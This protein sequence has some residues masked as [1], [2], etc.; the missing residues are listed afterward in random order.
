MTAQGAATCT[1]NF[2]ND[3]GDFAWENASNWSGDVLPSSS[4]VACVPDLAQ[5][6]ILSSGTHNILTLQSEEALTING[7][8]L[9]LDDAST[10]STL[11]KTL[12]FDGGDLGGAADVDV[13]ANIVY[14]SGD[15]NGSGT[16]STTGTNDI[17]FQTTGFNVISGGE[18]TSADTIEMNG[19]TIYLSNGADLSAT[20]AVNFNAAANI[21]LSGASAGSVLTTPQIN[22]TVGGNSTIRPVF[23]N[24][25]NVNVTSGTLFLYGGTGSGQHTGSFTGAG[26]VAFL[27]SNP[28]TN[29]HE[30]ASSSQLSSS[31]VVFQS[32]GAT[33]VN[34]TVNT[35]DLDFISNQ[36]TLIFNAPVTVGN[37]GGSGASDV[38]FNNIFTALGPAT[39]SISN[40]GNIT[41]NAAFDYQDT[42]WSQAGS[43]FNVE[44]DGSVN[45]LELIGGEVKSTNSSTVSTTQFS[46]RGLNNSANPVVD[47]VIV[48]A[49]TLYLGYGLTST[50]K[51]GAIVNSSSQITSNTYVS[52][53]IV[54]ESDG[55]GAKIVAG[56]LNYTAI[57]PLNINAPIELD[58]PLTMTSANVS[59]TA[60]SAG[61]SHSGSWTIPAGRTLT[62]GGTHDFV[63]AATITGAGDLSLISGQVSVPRNVSV[64]NFTM[65]T[66]S[67][68]T[69]E[70]DGSSAGVNYDV[71]N[72]TGTATVDGTLDVVTSNTYTPADGSEHD[73]VTAGTRS[74]NFATTNGLTSPSWGEWL[75]SYEPTAVRLTADS[76]VPPTANDSNESVDED[77]A[78]S[79]N[80]TADDT[81]GD[82]LTFAVVDQP[83]DGTLVFNNDGTYDYTPDSNFNGTDSFTFEADDGQETSNTATVTITVDPINDAPV[84]D[85]ASK[86]TDEDTAL[87]GTATANDVE[88][89][90]LTF[91]VVDQPSN[92]TLN[93]N[94]DGTY[95][96]T[97]NANYSGLDA[98][99]IKAN[100][101]TVDSNTATVSITVNA[102]N[103][104]PVAVNDDYTTEEDTTLTVAAPGVLD[105]DTDVE[106]DTLS[107]TVVNGPSNGSLTLNSDGSFDYTPNAGFVGPDSFTYKANDG[108]ADSNEATVTIDVTAAPVGY[109]AEIQQPIDDDGSSVFKAKRGTV[110]VKFT[111]NDANGPTCDLPPATIRVTQIGTGG[112]GVVNEDVYNGSSDSGDDFRITDC[113]YHYNLKA[114]N[115]GAGDYLVEILID[116][117]VVGEA[118]FKLN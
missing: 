97:P 68:L 15:Y 52:A 37:L 39:S 112:S 24:T 96:Y 98:F 14:Q 33:T 88:G 61:G 78:L 47:G 4:D 6:V 89:D 100:D 101:G 73:V 22:K 16:I 91:E 113:Q 67:T 93:F 8:T 60:G 1:R 58:G 69:T 54:V 42:L 25:G 32:I 106:G 108:S 49:G 46:L 116:G 57:Q 90:S 56:G 7:G 114:K 64:G 34:G 80:V 30:F 74:G 2:D 48:D 3:G 41:H 35:N 118:N 13:S 92:G 87:N 10:V 21:I 109:S 86:T 76:N 111:L 77:N 43:S 9:N 63:N 20:N 104:A 62:L 95:D 59:L 38:V 51:N 45:V 11:S 81:N 53:P 27:E 70:V 71:V 44:A 26:T 79:S 29:T 94:A 55:S 65:D 18:F 115:L 40:G 85:D 82:T 12:K 102:V 107:S 72:A 28:G 5:P 66:G 83:T 117:D 23:Q 50:L 84:A 19:G 75:L 99:T 105:N 36:G 103:D 17:I 31:R 110:P